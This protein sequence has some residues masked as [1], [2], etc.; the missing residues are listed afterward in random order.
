[1]TRRGKTGV[2]IASPWA[3]T[4]WGRGRLQRC[5]RQ[6]SGPKHGAALSDGE[7]RQ[8]SPALFFSG[9]LTALAPHR[10]LLVR[11]SARADFWLTDTRTGPHPS[12]LFESSRRMTRIGAT[13]RHRL[14]PGAWGAGIYQGL[15]NFFAGYL[16]H[17]RLSGMANRQVHSVR[18]SRRGQGSLSNIRK[19]A[20]RSGMAAVLCPKIYSLMASM[21]MSMR[22]SSLT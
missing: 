18:L 9:I 2:S 11:R 10:W 13:S 12:N 22:T 19:A 6:Q 20:A 5:V 17:E 15:P 16:R 21:A 3:A 14:G 7:A 8:Q 4:P 1:M